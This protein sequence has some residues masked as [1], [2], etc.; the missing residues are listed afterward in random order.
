MYVGQSEENI[1]EGE[2]ELKT[3]SVVWFKVQFVIKG[4]SRSYK[5]IDWLIELIFK[6]SDFFLD[7]SGPEIS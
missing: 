1:R 6:N 2:K 5:L 7:F 3:F 4:L